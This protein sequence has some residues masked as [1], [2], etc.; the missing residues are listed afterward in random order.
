MSLEKKEFLIADL[1][2]KE[3]SEGGLSTAENAVLQQ[4]LSVPENQQYYQKLI[5]F[6]TLKSKEAFYNSIDTDAAFERVR[7]KIRQDHTPV[8]SFFNYRQFLQ[9]A[10]VF[11]SPAWTCCCIYF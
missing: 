8:I 6:E 11:C 5:R 9:Y 7:E 3:L 4:W 10:A 2:R 1:I